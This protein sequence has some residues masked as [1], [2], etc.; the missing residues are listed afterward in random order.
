VKRAS[1]DAF[2]LALKGK[3]DRANDEQITH[4]VIPLWDLPKD[5]ERESSKNDER[6]Y[7]LQYFELRQTEYA[8]PDSIRRN[9]KAVFQQRDQPTGYNGENQRILRVLQMPV[10]RNSHEQIR[11]RQQKYGSSNGV[12]GYKLHYCLSWFSKATQND[13]EAIHL[14]SCFPRIE[15]ANLAAPP[16]ARRSRRPRRLAA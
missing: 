9:L 7:F 3:V 2:H 12:A 6:Y 5:Y 14:C 4:P 13:D 16:S 1:R 8:I 10:P 15:R 11:A